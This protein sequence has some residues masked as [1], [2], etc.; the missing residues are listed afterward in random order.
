MSWVLDSSV[1]LA[2]A[3]PDENSVKAEEVLKKTTNDKG[4]WVPALWWYE[5]SNALVMAQ[6]RERIKEADRLKIINLFGLLTIQTDS[7]FLL[8]NIGYLQEIALNHFL[9]VYDASYLELALRKG[10]GLA[11]FD[12]RLQNAAIHAGVRTFFDYL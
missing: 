2:W 9:S 7:S 1:T 3:L 4:F 11:T 5:I 10:L 12:R 8:E 6:R